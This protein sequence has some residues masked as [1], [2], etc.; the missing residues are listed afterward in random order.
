MVEKS[1]KER[2]RLE[3]MAAAIKYKQIY[4]DYE[5]LICSEGFV[6]NSYYIIAGKEDNFQHLTGVHT[7][8]KPKEFYFKCIQGV[9]SDSDFDFIKIGQDEKMVKGTVRR[10]MQS[11]PNMMELFKEGVQTEEG[12]KKNKVFCSFATADGKCTLGF[13]DSQ[14]ARPKTLL[15]GNELNNPKPVELILRKKSGQDLF[16]EFILGNKDTVLKYREKIEN[17]VSEELLKQ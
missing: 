15:K 6:Q 13:S 16:H 3:L 1:F 12:F 8:L 5:Y 17:L 4:V 14:K 10:K 9:L 2:V 11:L 7:N